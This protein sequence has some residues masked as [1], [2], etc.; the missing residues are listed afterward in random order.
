MID[1][2]YCRVRRIAVIPEQRRQG[3][4]SQ[5]LHSIFTLI[6]RPL[7]VARVRESNVAAAMLFRQAGYLFDPRIERETDPV[8]G[9]EY[10]EFQKR[11]RLRQPIED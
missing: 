8:T 11:K 2:D 10:Y 4:A 9:D 5:L 6:R 7:L 1:P 3:L